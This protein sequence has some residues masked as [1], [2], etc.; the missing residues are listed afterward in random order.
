MAALDAPA[1][2]QFRIPSGTA[3]NRP[4][5]GVPGRFYYETDTGLLAFDTGSAWVDWTQFAQTLTQIAGVAALTLSAPQSGGGQDS[6]Y[7]VLRSWN[8]T[9]PNTVTFKVGTNGTLRMSMPSN[10]SWIGGNLYQE[11]P[12]SYF[13]SGANIYLGASPT[14]S[15]LAVASGVIYQLSTSRGATLRVPITFNPTSS[16]AATAAFALGTSATPSVVD[17]ASIP[18]GVTAG[19]AL[20]LALRVPPDYYF[21]VTTTNATIGTVTEELE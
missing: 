15:V 6:P 18:A 5:F 10:W 11:T 7:F 16:A 20:P 3:A 19:I 21:S 2:G 14:Q 4:A 9:N 8:G 13:Q 17:T 12:T 1:Q